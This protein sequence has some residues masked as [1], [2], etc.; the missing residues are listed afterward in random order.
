[1]SARLLPLV[2][3]VARSWT[4]VYTR[5]LPS[6]HADARRAEIE[7]DLWELQRDAERGRVW[8]PSAQVVGRLVLGAADDVSWRLEQVS[9]ADSVPLRRTIACMA[10]ALSAVVMLWIGSGM[11]G[12]ASAVGERG[13]V[14]NCEG[15]GT[16]PE[17]TAELRL[18]VVSCTGAYFLRRPVSIESPRD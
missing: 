1:M 6:A 12:S 11:I 5:G 4:R 15:P 13:A 3:A 16:S 2:V 9:F 7:S 8:A 10:A 14:E 17:S 18:R